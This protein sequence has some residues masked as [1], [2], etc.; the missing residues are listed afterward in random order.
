MSHNPAAEAWALLGTIASYR[1]ETFS[2]PAGDEARGRRGVR[3]VSF[4]DRGGGLLNIEVPQRYWW[5]FNWHRLR[6]AA[7]VSWKRERVLKDLD[8]PELLYALGGC[9]PGRAEAWMEERGGR[10][11][12]FLD[13][14]Q[15]YA[16]RN[17][18]VA[19]L[20]SEPPGRIRCWAEP[21]EYGT[22]VVYAESFRYSRF[23]QAASYKQV[24][25]HIPH[26]DM[27]LFDWDQLCGA[28]LSVDV[29]DGVLHGEM[30]PAAIRAALTL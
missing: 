3:V 13:E 9:W 22:A 14:E 25:W 1:T 19:V 27:W 7:P 30:K 21:D 5:L 8:G 18:L 17:V 16:A 10:I 6:K 2:H 20:A 4:E 24:S 28:K 12:R 23:D 15:D 26:W 29:W 11:H